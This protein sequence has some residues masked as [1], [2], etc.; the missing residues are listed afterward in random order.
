MLAGLHHLMYINVRT[1]L[2]D[3][4]HVVMRPQKLFSYIHFRDSIYIIL[5]IQLLTY[6]QLVYIFMKFNCSA[7]LYYALPLTYIFLFDS[8]VLVYLL[9]W[10]QSAYY[11]FAKFLLQ[12]QQKLC[13]HCIIFKNFSNTIVL[14]LWYATVTRDEGLC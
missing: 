13:Y 3:C 2:F 9:I 14:H 12:I 6:L 11:F 4:I 1:G 10:I 7:F 8:I 5:I